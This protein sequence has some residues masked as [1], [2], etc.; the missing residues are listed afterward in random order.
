VLEVDVSDDNVPAA[1][2]RIA[3]WLEL[4]GGLTYPEK[5]VT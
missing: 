2:D 4:T 5:I 3:Q 1:A